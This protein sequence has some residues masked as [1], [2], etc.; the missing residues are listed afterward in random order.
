MKMPST[1]APFRFAALA[2]TASLFPISA[3]AAALADLYALAV[4]HDLG[5]RAA[6]AQQ[7]AA[8]ESRPQALSALLPQLSVQGSTQYNRFRVISVTDPNNTS[9]SKKRETYQSNSYT[10]QLTQTLFNWS[11]FK[12][13][14]A[15]DSAAAQAQSAYRAAEQELILRVAGAYFNVLTAEATLRADLDAQAAYKQSYEQQEAKYKG[16]LASVTDARNAQASYD[17]STTVVI[18]DTTALSNAK[19][20]L[21]VI[22]GRPVDRVDPLRE[23]ISLV[24][25]NPTSVDAWAQ[26]AAADNLTVM[27]ARHAV[28]AAR[29]E[30][31]AAGGRR[32]PT[33]AAVGSTGRDYSDSAFGYDSQSDFV[34]LQLNWDLFTGGQISSAVRQAEANYKRATAQYEL[35]VRSTD[36]S[37]RDSFDGVINGIAAVKSASRAVASAQS[38]VVAT[39]VGFK[40]GTRTI[41]D[42]LNTRQALANAQKAVAQARYSYLYS[43]LKLKGEVGQLAPNDIAEL[44][45]LMVRA[46]QPAAITQ[47]PFPQ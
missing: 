32:L 40:V 22:V 8:L 26:T 46:A 9:Y 3:Q 2:L 1:K 27:A 47:P 10:V 31:A 5:L 12:A 43:L 41:I 15:A 19:R 18:L 4:D 33:L 38:S 21:A 36:Q 42:T 24:P 28:E 17:A 7:S 16:G 44:D 35:Q 23:E 45:S 34:G 25:P 30:V 13:L 20:A 11:A 14:A 37:V 6:E 39:E 29:Q